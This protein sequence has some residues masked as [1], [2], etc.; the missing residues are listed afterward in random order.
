MRN[1]LD[2]RVSIQCNTYNQSSYITDAMNGFVM[3]QTDFPFVA[4]I[5][6][7]ASTDGEQE[8][9]QKYVDE[10]FD[11]SLESGFK[12][13]ETEDAFW[14]S[15]QHKENKN[16]HFVV[17]CLKQNLFKN[18]DKKAKVVKDWCNARYIA[19]CEGDDYWIDPLKM[20]RQVGF[21]EMHPD[22]SM[23]IHGA[24]VKNESVREVWTKCETIETREYF[25]KDVF[26]DWV[27]PTASIVYR[28]EVVDA[29][30]FKHYDWVTAGDI[31]LILKGMHTGRVW[32]MAEHMSVYRMNDGSLMAKSFVETVESRAAMCRHYQVLM[33]NF[34][35]VDRVFCNH[36]IASFNYSRFRL[37]KRWAVKL[38]HLIVSIKASPKYVFRKFWRAVTN[39]NENNVE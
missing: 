26:P 9:I 3:Q 10:H 5:I 24:D 25:S 15:A 35:L 29:Y 23:C 38:K 18:P 7:D 17:V 32:G 37:E 19:L 21:L 31:V 27:V 14:I 30:P 20:Q 2:F 12:E 33:M 8:V 13:W 1:M 39:G 34:P 22:F 28:R 11:H 6:D 4:V 16:C 36:Y